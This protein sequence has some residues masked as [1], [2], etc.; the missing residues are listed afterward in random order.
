[1]ALSGFVSKLT[2]ASFTTISLGAFGSVGLV[3]GIAFLMIS[4]VVGK[5]AQ[6]PLFVWLP[7]AMA[8]VRTPVS[9]LIPRCHHGDR[10]CVFDCAYTCSV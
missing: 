6:L 9:A 1:M 7:D 8:R 3:S 4:G 2:D 5:S 10:R